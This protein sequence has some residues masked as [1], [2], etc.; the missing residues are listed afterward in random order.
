MKAFD[1]GLADHIVSAVSPQTPPVLAEGSYIVVHAAVSRFAALYERIRN[2]VDYKDEHLL[3]KSAVRR[4][5]KRQLILE[6][7]PFVIASQLLRELISAR[8]LPNGKL[9][10]SLIE[11]VA[12]RVRKYREI[13]RCRV[14]S[15]AHLSWLLG[16]VAV[17]IEDVL[18]DSSREKALITYLYERLADRVH[19][20]GAGIEE[21]DLRL[22]IYIAASK[23]LTKADDEMLAYKLI[24][25]YLPEWIRPSD[26]IESPQA[27]AERLIGVE[28]RIRLSL[29]H[30]LAPRIQ[31]AIKPWAAS[32]V[33]LRDTLA[34]KPGSAAEIL[35]SPESLTDAVLRMT[36]R[37]YQE[38]KGR[39]RRGAVH[40]TLYLFVTKMLVAL[41]LEA[42]VEYAL[43]GI[44]AVPALVI[45]LLLP[46]GLMVLVSLFIRIPGKANTAR[47]QENVLLLLTKDGIPVRE[48]RI[49]RKRRGLTR[50]L[51]S[52]VYLLMFLVTFGLITVILNALHFTWVSISIFLF[53]LCV[54][55]FFAFRLR[56]SAREFVIVE[57]RE[58]F[59]TVIVDFLSYPILRAGQ[60]LSRSISRLNVFLFILD[61]L[62]EAPFKMFLGVLEEWFAFMKEKK[63]E[64][65]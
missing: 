56:Q 16:I 57:G 17:E 62:V 54:V 18:V 41:V 20:Q 48:I 24:R 25:A 32:L 12:L 46:P 59:T 37:R 7:D 43:Y 14:G 63:E 28:R 29:R 49:P 2:A 13:E 40:A 8:Y 55:S 34:E 5:L 3:R 60:W 61:F 38:A 52:L 45:N 9:P 51:F 33:I 15:D 4:I 22:Q 6:S 1:R 39:L 35:A 23:G 27:I 10:E 65:Q 58:R 64:L 42:P 11:D 30:P 44:I 19:I 50:A 31:R 21:A 36:E 47:I 53:F 26:W